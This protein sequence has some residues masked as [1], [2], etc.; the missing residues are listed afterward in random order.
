LRPEGSGRKRE[1]LQSGMG[2][3]GEEF[4]VRIKLHIL[5]RLKFLRHERVKKEGG[6]GP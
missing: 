4:S 2:R 6:G 3:E 1:K 5:G